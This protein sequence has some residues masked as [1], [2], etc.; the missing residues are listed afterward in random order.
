LFGK[1]KNN[2]SLL[3]LTRRQGLGTGWLQQKFPFR[4][5]PEIIL[6]QSAKEDYSPLFCS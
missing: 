6:H 1:Q 2:P 3:T 4:T 5:E